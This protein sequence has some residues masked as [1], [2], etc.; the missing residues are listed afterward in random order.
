MGD[1]YI[2]VSTGHFHIYSSR[3]RAMHFSD[4]RRAA[5][6]LTPVCVHGAYMVIFHYVAYIDLYC[7]LERCH[8]NAPGTNTW[9]S[10]FQGTWQSHSET[11]SK[12]GGRPEKGQ[13]KHTFFVAPTPFA[14]AEAFWECSKC[15][16]EHPSIS[17]EGLIVQ[18]VQYHAGNIGYVPILRYIKSL[19]SGWNHLHDWIFTAGAKI[20][21]RN[22]K[23]SHSSGP[24]GGLFGCWYS[25][26]YLY[27][28]K[29][30]N[31]VLYRDILKWKTAIMRFF[32]FLWW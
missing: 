1:I 26:F 17:R 9:T 6:L 15:R 25:F 5:A 12:T 3:R 29:P 21:V 8:F 24:N 10:M 13:K 4:S 18:G 31:M 2:Q 30:W 14:F 11:A 19:E 16:V 20:S 32:F 7:C 23:D 28:S 27:N 22:I